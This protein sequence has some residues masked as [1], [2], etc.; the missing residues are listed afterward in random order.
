LINTN[1]LKFLMKWFFCVL[2]LW[3][4]AFLGWLKIIQYKPY[5]WTS[6]YQ[7]FGATEGLA[8]LL[9]RLYP[10]NN[11]VYRNPQL[12]YI[13]HD[14]SQ[15]PKNHKSTSCKLSE[16][17][18]QNYGN[19]IYRLLCGFRMRSRSHLCIILESS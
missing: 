10:Q 4:S 18:R 19:D 16:N 8:N 5:S 11:F 2:F 17:W 13:S 15:Q 3:Y 14:V 1:I 7:F 12:T 9:L 6:S